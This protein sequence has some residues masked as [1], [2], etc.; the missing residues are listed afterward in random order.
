MYKVLPIIILAISFN[1]YP[2][3]RTLG[4]LDIDAVFKKYPEL[5]PASS[6]PDVFDATT[7][8]S[9]VAA[10]NTAMKDVSSSIQ[11]IMRKQLET[12]FQ[13]VSRDPR[14]ENVVKFIEARR[15]NQNSKTCAASFKKESDLSANL[16]WNKQVEAKYS[17]EN[18]KLENTGSLTVQYQFSRNKS[19]FFR[20]SAHA[21]KVSEEKAIE[22]NTKLVQELAD[23]PIKSIR[24][25][26]IE[27]NDE[28]ILC[29]YI[30]TR[31]FVDL[32]T[33]LKSSELDVAVWVA[34]NQ[35]IAIKGGEPTKSDY[36]TILSSAEINLPAE[37]ITN[38]QIFQCLANASST[39]GTKEWN[40]DFLSAYTFCS[41]QTVSTG[42]QREAFSNWFKTKAK[43]EPKP[44]KINTE[45]TNCTG[46]ADSDDIR[47]MFDSRNTCYTLIASPQE[48]A[49]KKSLSYVANKFSQAKDFCLTRHIL[50][51]LKSGYAN[52]FVVYGGSHLFQTYDNLTAEICTKD[53]NLASCPSPKI[54]T[55]IP[56]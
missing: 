2:Q 29:D 36:T 20:G 9:L 24:T 44:Y 41:G 40:K 25:L 6:T 39:I 38:Y 15:M 30:S 23:L 26:I 56:L 55:D 12:K 4:T 52:V 17:T 8:T 45:K 22:F 46:A 18:T 48:S 37:D 54:S 35:G 51:A 42:E 5:L 10:C 13:A 34:M 7:I 47:K 43:E 53:K 21:N 33:L 11:S 28:Q 31:M 27:R 3:T 49:N 14:Y 32:A 50:N 1:V 16:I 19:L